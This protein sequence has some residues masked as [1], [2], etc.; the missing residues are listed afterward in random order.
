MSTVTLRFLADEGCD[1]GVVRAGCIYSV[2]AKICV[3]LLQ[4]IQ[5]TRLAAYDML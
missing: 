1:F 4:K 2:R 3:H 5:L